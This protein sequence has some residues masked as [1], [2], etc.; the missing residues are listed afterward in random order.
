MAL[1]T[2]SLRLC[3]AHLCHVD[4]SHSQG[5]VAQDSPVLVPLPPLQHNLQFVGISLKEMRVL[6]RKTVQMVNQDGNQGFGGSGPARG[7]HFSVSWLWEWLV[8]MKKKCQ[9]T[10][11]CWVLR[12][13]IS[14]ETSLSLSVQ[15]FA[16]YD[17]AQSPGLWWKR[18]SGRDEGRRVDTTHNRSGCILLGPKIQTSSDG[19][20][21]SVVVDL[22]G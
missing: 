6:K 21:L 14:L 16:L 13:Y 4:E 11:F 3:S 2:C 22:S 7:L 5:F 19:E 15:M 9:R 18:C 1:E 10:W 8:R 17:S 20:K 12:V